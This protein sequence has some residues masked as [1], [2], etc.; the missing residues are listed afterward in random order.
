VEAGHPDLS[1]RRAVE[2]RYFIVQI[3]NSSRRHGQYCSLARALDVVGDRWT[4]L[5]VRELSLGPRRFT[6]LV[7]GLPGISRN[8]LTQ[9]LRELER[10]AVV[11]RDQLPPPAARQ[12]YALTPDG[13]ELAAA[14][15]PLASW[16]VRR[17]GTRRRGEA[18]RPHWAAVAMAG[19]AERSVQFT[20]DEPQVYESS[21]DVWRSFC[22]TC[23]S[24]ISYRSKRF[25]GEVHFYV[26]VM[27]QP[28]GYEPTAHVYFSEHVS[29]F[30]TRDNLV[31]YERTA[32]PAP[33]P[34]P[35]PH[36]RG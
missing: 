33:P 11:E 21:P 26:G 30:D 3:M 34:S 12:V 1:L 28:D 29:W 4:L 22:G 35:S 23:G 2:N 7:E 6:D 31:R 25:P 15:L 18:Y 24:P 5:I 32:G 8:L 19:F 20:R 16:G 27:D 17:L 10:E 14:M 36:E 13:R 9:R